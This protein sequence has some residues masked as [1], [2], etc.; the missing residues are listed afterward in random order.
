MDSKQLTV[1][2]DALT[3]AVMVTGSQSAFERKTGAKQQ[4]VSYW[5]KHRRPLPG[6]YVLRTER[7]TGVSRH[8]LRPDLY[9]AELSSPPPLVGD[10]EGF[11]A[12]GAPIVP[13][14]RSALLHRSAAR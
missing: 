6:E 2:I 10:H 1:A 13:C 9:P 4:K 11:V 12:P 8:R 3:E 14:D 5:L 7:E